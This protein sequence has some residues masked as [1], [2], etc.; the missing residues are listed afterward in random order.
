MMGPRQVAQGALFYEFSI[1]GHVPGDHLLRR[2]DRFV[3]LSDIRCFLSPYYSSI[4]RPSIDSELMIR[5]SGLSGGSAT[6]F[7]SIWR[8]AGAVGSILGS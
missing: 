2:I 4:G 7:I 6:R 8:I 5:A 3:D 1:E